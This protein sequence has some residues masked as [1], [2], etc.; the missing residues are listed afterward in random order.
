MGKIVFLDIDGTLVNFNQQMPESALKALKA[1]RKNGHKLALCTG[2]TYGHIYPWL[3]DIGFDAIVA[4]AGA[5]VRIGE[6][7]LYHHV[8]DFEKM[9][10]LEGL[11][12][13]HKIAYV[14]QGL[15]GR[16][17][18]KDC[19]KG[20]ENHFAA[21]NPDYN[22]EL[23]GMEQIEY[24][25]EKHTIESIMFFNSNVGIGQLQKEIDEEL[26]GYFCV[27]GASYETDREHNGEITCKGIHKADGMKRVAEH[28]S[29]NPT[30][31]I[32]FG[33]GPNDFEMLR[34]AHIGVAMGNGVESLKNKADFVTDD[35][36]RDGIYKAFVHLGLIEE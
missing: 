19:I 22:K 10:G 7:V 29:L 1:A 11:L 24:I 12:R 35:I 25:S 28:F 16:M 30:E 15:Y 2:R 32:A 23:M 21:I 14:L 31:I 8:I 4:S 18:P 27:T 13:K 17:V 6:E 3:L 36:E 33:D 34:Y 5:Y 9:K 20:I 26:N